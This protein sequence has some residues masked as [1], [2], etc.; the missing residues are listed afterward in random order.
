MH[1]LLWQKEIHSSYVIDNIRSISLF[2]NI[3]SYIK[4]HSDMQLQMEHSG[5]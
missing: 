2:T 1:L 4:L 5:L 3:A